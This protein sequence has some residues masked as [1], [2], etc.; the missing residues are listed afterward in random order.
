MPLCLDKVMNPYLLLLILMW[1]SAA[2][3]AFYKCVVNDKTIYQNKPCE[4]ADQVE[5]VTVHKQQFGQSSAE[6]NRYL[7]Q[8]HQVTQSSDREQQLIQ[9]KAELKALQDQLATERQKR[10]TEIEKI[11]N[12]PN[13][14]I[15]KQLLNRQLE[16]LST[17]YQT[18]IVAK[19]QEIKRLTEQSLPTSPNPS[20]K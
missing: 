20:K 19:T 11:A 2:S 17:E 10:L 9:L 18:K 7:K 13:G 6:Y 14:K 8:S 12:T 4:R 3:G 16:T 1:H 5:E 15:Q